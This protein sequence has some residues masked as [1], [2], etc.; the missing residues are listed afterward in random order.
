MA[1]SVNNKFKWTMSAAI[2]KP[3][4]Q[5]LKYSNAVL[6]CDHVADYWCKSKGPSHKSCSAANTREKN[7]AEFMSTFEA[8]LSKIKFACKR[9][10]SVYS[11][12][13]TWFCLSELLCFPL[14]YSF[15]ILARGQMSLFKVSYQDLK[16]LLEEWKAEIK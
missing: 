3:K 9:T 15:I 11:A 8:L 7:L 12:L 13:Y 2:V 5:I 4:M 14:G 1:F 6:Q 16:L 10:G